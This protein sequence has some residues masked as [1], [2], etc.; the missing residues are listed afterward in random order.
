MEE[1]NHYSNYKDQAIIAARQ[2]HYSDEVI[3]KL[4]KAKT[5]SEIERIM[6][7][8]RKES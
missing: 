7:T 5:D 3:E 6:S 4:K 2:L 1:T 8:A